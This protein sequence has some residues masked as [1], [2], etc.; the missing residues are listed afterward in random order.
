MLIGFKEGVNACCGSVPY[1]GVDACG[2]VKKVKDY[3]LCDRPDEYVWWDSFHPTE[4]IHEQYGKALWNGS[5][6]ASSEDVVGP[7]SLHNLFFLDKK[8]LTIADIFDDPDL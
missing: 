6:A 1:G 3:K 2:G 7:Y 5:A 4:R 8:K